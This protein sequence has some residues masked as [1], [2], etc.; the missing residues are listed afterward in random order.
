MGPGEAFRA[1]ALEA[2]GAVHAA[3]LVLAGVRVAIVDL[4]LAV[5][6]AV[7]GDACAFVPGASLRALS[8]VLAG[9]VY[10]RSCGILTERTV[11]SA[12]ANTR[13][14][15]GICA[16]H[17]GTAIRAR[18]SQAIVDQIFAFRAG[19][20]FRT[21]ARVATLP[22]VEAGAPIAAGLVVR[23]EVEILVAEEAAP[24]LVAH[25]IPRFRAAAVDATW[26]PLALIAQRSFPSRLTSRIK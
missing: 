10:T 1:N 26:V 19:E 12:R 3:T 21:F 22:G 6:T 7:A 13:V 14:V 16:A 9:L 11:E 24:S 15:S 5:D 23:A 8:S 2:V 18:R 25:A 4:V 17:T 20:S